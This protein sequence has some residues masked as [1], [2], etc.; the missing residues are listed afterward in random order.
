M[1]LYQLRGSRNSRVSHGWRVVM[2]T[3][4]LSS[5]YGFGGYDFAV[6][7]PPLPLDFD[8]VMGIYPR[9]EGSFVLGRQCRE[10]S[11]EDFLRE[12]DD[13]FVIALSLVII[14]SL[15]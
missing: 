11:N 14:G 10:S 15:R 9:F 4:D 13:V 6:I 12:D 3:N 1:L 5:L 2:L 7:L 8:K